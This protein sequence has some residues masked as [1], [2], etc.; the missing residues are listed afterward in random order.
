ML[1]WWDRT[2]MLLFPI[3]YP[4][5]SYHSLACYTELF[6]MSNSLS[7]SQ[8]WSKPTLSLQFGTPFSL[9]SSSSDCSFLHNSST[10]PS[11]RTPITHP[12]QPWVVLGPLARHSLL[13]FIVLVFLT[14]GLWN[15]TSHILICWDPSISSNVQHSTDTTNKFG[16]WWT[17][18]EWRIKFE[19]FVTNLWF[20]SWIFSNVSPWSTLSQHFS[21]YS[22]TEEGS[23][24]F[25]IFSGKKVR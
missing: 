21:L 13:C 7:S 17:I 2:E 15:H 10:K 23:V 20:L 22:A 14:S 4:S 25:H 9:F 12:T 5:W 11:I 6:K 8:S 19:F 16:D 24:Y 1:S 18:A 3:T